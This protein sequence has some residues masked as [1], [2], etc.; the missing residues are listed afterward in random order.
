MS[1]HYETLFLLPSDVAEKDV[2]AL[3]KQLETLT[4]EASGSVKSFDAWGRYRLAYAV[5]KHDTGIYML[6]RYVVNETTE[7]FKKFE[8]YLRVKCT[9]SVL[10]Y[11]HVNLDEEDYNRPYS[12]PEPVDVPSDRPRRP[13]RPGRE[14]RGSR[15]AAVASKI[16]ESAPA[17]PAASAEATAPKAPVEKA[18]EAPVTETKNESVEG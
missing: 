16:T 5:R 7:F 10:R 4:K 13:E 12:R 6:A 15:G 8:S 1:Y 17:K 9:E 3:E 18:E 14:N 11:V 2:K